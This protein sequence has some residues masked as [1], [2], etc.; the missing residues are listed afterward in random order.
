VENRET[1]PLQK[2]LQGQLAI[3][4]AITGSTKSLLKVKVVRKRRFLSERGYSWTNERDGLKRQRVFQE[5]AR[6]GPEIRKSYPASRQLWVGSQQMMTPQ[7]ARQKQSH[8]ESKLGLDIT[9]GTR[10]LSF[11]GW[12]RNGGFTFAEKNLSEPG[13]ETKDNKT[14]GA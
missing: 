12:C 5:R 10:R 7:E 8:R 13:T 6:R 3:I 9:D 1:W 14:I 11:G 2:G 4:P